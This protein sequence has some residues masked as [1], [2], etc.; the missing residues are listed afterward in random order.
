MDPKIRYPLIGNPYLLGT[1]AQQVSIIPSSKPWLAVLPD[2][3]RK[4]RLG[5]AYGPLVVRM[6]RAGLRFKF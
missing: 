3:W 2:S 4:F 6:R 5:F 1:L